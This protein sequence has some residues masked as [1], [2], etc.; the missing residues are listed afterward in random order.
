MCGYARY[1]PLC[2]YRRYVLMCAYGRYGMMR[3]C[4]RYGLLPDYIIYDLLVRRRTT[5]HTIFSASSRTVG[6]SVVH[7]NLCN[8]GTK[9]G[10]LRAGQKVVVEL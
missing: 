4:G 10:K 2:G 7:S 8:G 6:Q 3:G 9:L 1:G 5:L